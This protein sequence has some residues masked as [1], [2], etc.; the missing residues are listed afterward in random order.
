[1]HSLQG[2]GVENWQ[3]FE[4]SLLPRQL[5]SSS[6]DRETLFTESRDA[7]CK[8]IDLN[9]DKTQSDHFGQYIFFKG[10]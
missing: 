9:A 5:L 2:R 7:T 10:V 4:R 8:T 6:S 1:M 3:V